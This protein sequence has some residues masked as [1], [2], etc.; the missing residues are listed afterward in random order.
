VF[1]I[2]FSGC[3]ERR[4]DQ[5]LSYPLMAHDRKTKALK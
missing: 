1:V 5:V 3:R 2:N 4:V